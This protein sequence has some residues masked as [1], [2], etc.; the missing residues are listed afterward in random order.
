MESIWGKCCPVLPEPVSK[1]KL[2]LQSDDPSCLV[3]AGDRRGRSC[4]KPYGMFD[5]AVTGKSM[6][7]VACG[8]SVCST[9]VPSYAAANIPFGVLRRSICSGGLDAPPMSELCE[10]YELCLDKGCAYCCGKG[11]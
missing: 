11:R 10:L 4:L 9:D 5:S 1:Y 7:L 2:G 3:A 6:C 8:F